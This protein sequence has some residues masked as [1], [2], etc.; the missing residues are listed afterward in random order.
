[1]RRGG[2]PIRAG[3]FARTRSKLPPIPPE[4]TITAW[5]SSSKSP[6]AVR[7]LR[8]PRGT[9]DGSS[10][11]PRTPPT[12]P[13]VTTSSSTRCRNAAVALP[14]THCLAHPARERFDEGG[15][16]A[17]GDVEARDRV[18]VPGSGVAASFGPADDREEPH[19]PL[20]Q[21]CP[22]LPRGEV[23]VGLG[24]SPRPQIRRV[25]AVEA[26]K[27]CA[28]LPVL[29]GQVDGILDADPALLRRIDKEQPAEGPERLPADV[30]LGFLVNEDDRAAAVEQLAGGDQAGQP[31][32][33]HDDVGIGRHGAPPD[34]EAPSCRTAPRRHR[35]RRGSRKP[36]AGQTLRWTAHR[37]TA[38]RG[39][40]RMRTCP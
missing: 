31:G 20:A 23:H 7:E 17:P 9:A 38:C 12:T 19:A 18:A 21:P 26:V 2:L 35:G 32:P 16:G 25:R 30:L 29:P 6:T 33:H 36:P 37:R 15:A 40:R 1:M 34:C 14:C 13:S 24:P 5:A 28:A 3:Q 27:A 39:D 4:V 8:A 10:T 22:L 11:V